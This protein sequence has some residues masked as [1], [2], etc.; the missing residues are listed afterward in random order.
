MLRICR[1]LC[2]VAFHS[3]DHA[4]N[5][6]RA[7]AP[8]Y[9]QTRPRRPADGGLKPNSSCWC[10]KV[11]TDQR[12]VIITA[13]GERTLPVSSTNLS[14]KP[15]GPRSQVPVCSS[16]KTEVAILS[17]RC[18]A[19]GGRRRLVRDHMHTDAELLPSEAG[20]TELR[21]TPM[22][23]NERKTCKRTWKGPR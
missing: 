2:V 20:R 4:S 16:A 7:L 17:V 9:D 23:A 3:N 19:K 10:R 21:Y 22:L 14:V 11:D 1:S 18:S 15:G 12:L 5:V 6:Q 13:T 8:D